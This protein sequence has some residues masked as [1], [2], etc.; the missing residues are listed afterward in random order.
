VSAL[1]GVEAALWLSALLFFVS[2]AALVISPAA[3]LRTM[4][5]AA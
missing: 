3:R 4:P 2:C 1:Y 5:A